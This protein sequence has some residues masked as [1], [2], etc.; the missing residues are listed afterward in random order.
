MR[1]ERGGVRRGAHRTG[2][3]RGFTLLEVLVAFTLLALVLG[4]AYA[5]MGGALT[6]QTRAE[7]AA[8]GLSRAE[9]ALAR[10][11]R[12]WPLTEGIQRRNDG[13]WRTDVTIR[14]QRPGDSARWRALGLQPLAV[15]VEVIPPGA[16]A[17]AATL[18]TLRLGAPR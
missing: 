4:A 12:D 3:D 6:A 18:R 17:P 9:S 5:A 7:I 15:T 8:E 11:G 10:L 2:R 14:P 13:G 16:G 1:R